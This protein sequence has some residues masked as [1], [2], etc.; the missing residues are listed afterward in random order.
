MF[1]W[2]GGEGGGNGKFEFFLRHQCC[3]LPSFPFFFFFFFFFLI[4]YFKL[5]QNICSFQVSGKLVHN[6]D[7]A[8]DTN[9]QTCPFIDQIP[10]ISLK[11]L[12]ENVFKTEFIIE[13]T[14]HILREIYST[15]S[16]QIFSR[17]S[18]SK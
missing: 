11:T 16:N 15:K 14:I 8:D 10:S 12:C 9:I 13:A 7:E 1:F 4:L 3:H 5:G 18:S 6:S 2:G 17:R